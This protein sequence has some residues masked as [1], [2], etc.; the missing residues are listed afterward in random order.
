[1][2]RDG[3]AACRLSD[4][5]CFMQH[6]L[7]EAERVQS[8]VGGFYAVYNYYGFGFSESVYTGA[9][10]LEL[11]DR[12]HEVGREVAVEICYKRRH[13]AWYRLDL[14]VDQRIIVEVKAGDAMPKYA[15][16][17]LLNYLHATKFE[18]GVLLYFGPVPKFHRFV[19][20]PKRER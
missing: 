15:A 13:V 10:E 1:M 19:D 12:G 5:P 20:H 11:N 6:E 14:I 18:V 3:T 8:I 17:Q 16:S 2:R 7:L 4:D 9:L